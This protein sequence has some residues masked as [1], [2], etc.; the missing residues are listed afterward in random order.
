MCVCVLPQDPAALKRSRLVPLLPPVDHAAMAYE[1][2]GKYF[3]EEHP[4]I[5]ALTAGTV[6]CVRVAC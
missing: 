6:L 2:F 3:L 1:E 4:D 5:A